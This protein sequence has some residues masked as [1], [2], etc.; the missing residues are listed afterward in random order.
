MSLVD[1]AR[2][3]AGPGIGVYCDACTGS[4]E[5]DHFPDCPMLAMPRI[6]AVLEAVEAVTIAYEESR[7]LYGDGGSQMS[8]AVQTLDDALEG[9]PA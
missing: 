1:S 4:P 7:V 6:V 9:E 2:R 8:H 5:S 3:L